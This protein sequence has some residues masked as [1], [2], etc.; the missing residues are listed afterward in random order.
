[1]SGA[2]AI[3]VSDI[4][5]TVPPARVSARHLAWMIGRRAAAFTCAG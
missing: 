5:P 4:E 1:M 3:D 2:L